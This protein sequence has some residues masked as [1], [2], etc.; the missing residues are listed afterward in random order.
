MYLN[1]HSYYSLRYGTLS[2]DQL[3]EAAVACQADTIA[4]TD[5]NSSQGIPEFVKKA[6]QAGIKPIA[7]I[8]FRNGDELLFIGLARDREGFRELNEY[9]GWHNLHKRPFKLAGWKFNHVVI[10]YPFGDK[11]P[12][13]LLPNEFTAIRPQQ[14]TKL[15][16]SPYRLHQ[17][18]L[19]VWQPVAFADE[20]SWLIHKCLRAI[21]HNTL[22]SKLLP[23]Q[24][25]DRD[26]LMLPVFKLMVLFEQYPQIIENTLN[27]MDDCSI[28]FAFKQSKNKSTYSQTKEDEIGRAHV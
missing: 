17:N 27:I 23:Q 1:V 5:I 20:Q 15:V 19:V 21:D 2:I 18:K 7:G 28:S 11:E 26:Q 16:T 22:F 4:L 3:V 8:E 25:A 14:L 10:L 13:E 12:A 24:Y 6:S 9:L